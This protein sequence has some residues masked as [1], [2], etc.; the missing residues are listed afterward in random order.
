MQQARHWI[1]EW[2]AGM[3]RALRRLAYVPSITCRR[4]ARFNLGSTNGSKEKRSWSRARHH[5]NGLGFFK[6]AV[7]DQEVGGSN[8]HTN[9]TH[10]AAGEHRWKRAGV[11]NLR[12]LR[13]PAVTQGLP[14]AS[15]ATWKLSRNGVGESVVCPSERIVGHPSIN[16]AYGGMAESYG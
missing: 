3:D 1:P 12:R 2:Q 14:V 8:T 4:R 7:R 11:S 16:T 5:Q 15:S 13:A 9:Q 6:T 10:L